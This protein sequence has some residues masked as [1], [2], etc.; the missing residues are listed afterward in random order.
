M[1]LFP[2]YLSRLKLFSDLIWFSFS[3]SN[4][5]QLKREPHPASTFVP[6]ELE[7]LA[8]NAAFTMKVPGGKTTSVVGNAEALYRPIIDDKDNVIGI[9]GIKI[10]DEIR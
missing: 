8:A 5:E 2:E 7:W 10:N 3:T 9:I 6:D 1:R 4:S